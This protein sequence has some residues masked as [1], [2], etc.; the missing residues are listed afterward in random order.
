MPRSAVTRTK[1]TYEIHAKIPVSIC[2]ANL[3]TQT[4]IAEHSEHNLQKPEMIVDVGDVDAQ[5]RLKPVQFQHCQHHTSA[6]WHFLKAIRP[7]CARFIIRI[8]LHIAAFWVKLNKH[9]E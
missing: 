8:P 2:T 5:N 4:G 3:L 1:S 6:F 7:F 9:L